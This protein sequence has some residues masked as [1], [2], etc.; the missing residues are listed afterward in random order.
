[1]TQLQGTS[2]APEDAKAE[3]KQSAPEEKETVTVATTRT[4]NKK[5]ALHAGPARA[6]SKPATP[7]GAA[8]RRRSLSLAPVVQQV[9]RDQNLRAGSTTATEQLSKTSGAA[10]FAS[11][12]RKTIQSRTLDDHVER[13]NR[14]RS[15]SASSG[16]S[17]AVGRARSV[18]VGGGGGSTSGVATTGGSS[19][20]TGGTSTPMPAAAGMMVNTITYA[21]SLSGG[22]KGSSL[23]ASPS[24]KPIAVEESLLGTKRYNSNTDPSKYATMSYWDNR[25]EW[26]LR[27]RSTPALKLPTTKSK[28]TGG[29]PSST[30]AQLSHI[31]QSS[32]PKSDSKGGE[33]TIMVD[34]LLTSSTSTRDPAASTQITPKT[35]VTT[36]PTSPTSSRSPNKTGSRANSSSVSP[37][38]GG[39]EKT[40]A[41]H[42][43]QQQAVACSCSSEEFYNV[44][45]HHAA[46]GIRKYL[47]ENY[48]WKVL[49]IGCGLSLFGIQMVKQGGY[50]CTLNTDIAPVC[51]KAMQK[52]FPQHQFALMDVLDMVSSSASPANV[53]ALFGDAPRGA[54]AHRAV[55]AGAM[56]AKTGGEQAAPSPEEVEEKFGTRVQLPESSVDVVVDKGVLDSLL[57]G[58]GGDERFRTCMEQCWTVLK[59]G[60]LF[61]GLAGSTLTIWKLQQLGAQWKF[62]EKI[63]LKEQGKY[64]MLVLRKRKKG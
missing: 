31:Q 58:R 14:G 53:D 23:S 16:R 49:H 39:G 21:T 8:G 3:L 42:V 27:E 15:L 11:V 47:G 38:R 18:G 45:Y 30:S 54:G 36:A 7:S 52:A 57:C 64:M 61:L 19:T 33:G 32:P 13:M 55:T 41:P 51:L 9:I 20:T 59:E 44:K 10:L 40:T 24:N 56:A 34:G 63:P 46:N 5:M 43:L 17:R 1:M 22:N 29:G 37:S 12:A 6:Q 50:V 60:G 48:H 62:L 4:E 28:Q 2:K 25:F 26:L 35:A